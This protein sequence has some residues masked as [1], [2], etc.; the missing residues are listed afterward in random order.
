MQI[1]WIGRGQQAL[2]D[3]GRGVLDKFKIDIN[4]PANLI[5]APNIRGVHR[6]TRFRPL[7]DD[8][9]GVGNRSDAVLALRKHGKIT[10]GTKYGGF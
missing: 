9:M 6:L 3:Q 4:D 2:V 10:A 7:V 5:W 8:L 1:A